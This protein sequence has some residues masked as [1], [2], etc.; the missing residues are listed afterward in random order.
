[1]LQVEQELQ[2]QYRTGAFTAMAAM[3]ALPFIP[4]DMGFYARG[5]HA[6]TVQVLLH[7]PG[8]PTAWVGLPCRHLLTVTS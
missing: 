5:S 2:A 6:A 3:D 4:M 7:N 1:M 8:T